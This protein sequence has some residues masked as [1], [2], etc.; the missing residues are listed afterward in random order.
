M[1]T[2]TYE[3]KFKARVTGLWKIALLGWAI[4]LFRLGPQHVDVEVHAEHS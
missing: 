3:I 4:K 2:D 1:A